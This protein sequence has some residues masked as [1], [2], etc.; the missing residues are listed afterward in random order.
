MT[1][2]VK[3][4]ANAGRQGMLQCAM[5]GKV[6]ELNEEKTMAGRVV[7]FGELLLRLAAPGNELL[8]Q[9]PH[10]DV[11]VGGAEANVA[12]AVAAEVGEA[13]V[14]SDDEDD[15]GNGNTVNSSANAS[16]SPP[17]CSN[18]CPGRRCRSWCPTRSRPG[19][20]NGCDCCFPSSGRSD[21][22][23]NPGMPR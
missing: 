1:P 5:A 6:H 22:F 7:C 4:V 13:E 11:H 2:L 14:V 15:V 9:R 8:L 17:N 18:P 23:R 20:G 16:G 12:P 19:C 21:S 10:L 3:T